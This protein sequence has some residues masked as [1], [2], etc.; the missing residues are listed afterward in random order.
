[1]TPATVTT[2]A[3]A[4]RV[5]AN[6]WQLTTAVFVALLV[7]EYLGPLIGIA[8]AVGSCVLALVFDSG[9]PALRFPAGGYWLVGILAT[10]L[11]S[12]VSANIFGAA[13]MAID[14][15]RDVGMA[16]SYLLFF[17]IGYHFAWSRK[18][19]VSLL[20][21]VV[22]AGMFISMVHL[23]RF[24]MVLSSG[25]TDLYAF[26]LEAGRGSVTQ[27]VAV[28]ACMLLLCEVRDRRWRRVVQFCA[29]LMV[30][31]V[32]FTLSR[33][34]MIN[35]VL[36]ALGMTGIALDRAG[37]M[38]ADL[39][40]FVMTAAATA[41][42]V[43]CVYLAIGSF[44]PAVRQFIDEFFL[45]RV[46]NSAN[47]L[48][49]TSLQTRQ[50]IADNYR[51]FEADQAMLQFLA[52]PFNGQLI[53]QGWGSSVRF[54]FET[55]SSKATFSRTEAPFLHN[56]YVYYLMK[57]GVVGL[58]LYAGFMAHLVWRAVNRAL[59]PSEALAGTQRR[60]QIVLVSA[61]AVGSVS[62]GGLGYPATYLA[63]A[64]LLGACYGPVR[65]ASGGRSA[66]V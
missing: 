61:L 59:W 66:G 25:V 31:S 32:L 60:V 24:A 2:T 36:V 38:S 9:M 65:P 63:M 17:V 26:R 30:T 21:G 62:T 7:A 53:G 3:P 11:V 6:W 57:A 16:V 22:A 35:L 41:A 5:S 15:Q 54:G 40:K 33:G 1:M 45:T 28:C 13:P 12:A 50:Q 10:G 48:A 52:Q 37:K 27:F 8:A 42:V 49:A 44:L 18:S 47:E 51:A 58:L 56:G 34:L 55:A 43:V 39:W 14:L 19:F 29:A 64:V 20:I 4:E 23:V 46:T